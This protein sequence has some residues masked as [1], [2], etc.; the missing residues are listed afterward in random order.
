MLEDICSVKMK[1][2]TERT[3]VVPYVVEVEVGNDVGG[4]VREDG[5]G[6]RE[7]DEQH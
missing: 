1:V 6:R 7:V 4:A 3:G 5:G 2:E